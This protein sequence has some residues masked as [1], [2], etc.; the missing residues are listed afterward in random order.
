MYLKFFGLQAKPF[1]TTPDPD[2]L[3]LSPGHKQALGSIIYGVREKK[4]IIAVTGQVGLGKTTILRSFLAQVDPVKQRVIYLLNPNLSFTGLLQTLLRELG[5]EP[6]KGDEADVVKQLHFVLI[7]E[8]RKGNTV[9]LMIDE[10]QNMPVATLEH[11]RVLYNLETPKDKLIQIVLLGQ[12][13]LDRVLDRHELRQVRQRIAVK[14]M[15]PPLS[16][17][18][19]YHYIQHRLDKAGGKGKKFFTNA[20]LVRIVREAKGIPRRLNIL[21]DNAL[22]TAFGY[23]KVPVTSSMAKEVISD[24]AGQPSRSLWKWAPLAAGALILVLA[25]VSFMPLIHSQFSNT[26]P[27]LEIGQLFEGEDNQNQD[28][29]NVEEEINPSNQGGLSFVE[30]AQTWLTESVPEV[31]EQ[32]RELAVSVSDSNATRPDLTASIDP[33]NQ[34]EDVAFAKKPLGDMMKDSAPVV[35]EESKELAAS[36][37]ATHIIPPYQKEARGLSGQGEGIVT[38]GAPRIPVEGTLLAQDESEARSEDP[39]ETN[40]VQPNPENLKNHSVQTPTNLAEGPASPP[41][42]D[43]LPPVTAAQKLVTLPE[44]PSKKPD[45]VASSLPVTKIMKEGDTLAELMQEVYGSASPS[46]LRW[47]LDHNRHIVNVRKIYPG[48]EIMFPPLNNVKS[49]K[50]PVHGARASVSHKGE[51]LSSSKKIL[52]RS[53]TQTKPNQAKNGAK[54]GPPYA[55]AIVREGDTLEELAKVVYG[56]SHPLYIQRVLDYNPQILNPK[57]IFPGQNIAFPRIDKAEKEGTKERSHPQSN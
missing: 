6:L 47:V 46:T 7:E 32:L 2:F 22:V 48:Q 23:K 39:T 37:T 27:L 3:Y 29:L 43:I 17:Q 36:E 41:K 8:Y 18:E 5:Y 24:L 13:E 55:V 53:S 1:H 10:A 11:L 15:I 33:N 9:V 35:S 51:K 56:S 26:S 16:K 42:Q 34:E 14:A 57:K 28:L 4:G 12:P 45:V 38:D 21:C 52:T 30:R 19:S 25:L 54:R 50:R 31:L 49:Q 44:S 20:A 40:A